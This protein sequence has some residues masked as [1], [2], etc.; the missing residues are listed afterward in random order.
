MSKKNSNDTIGNRT[1]ELPACSAVPQPTASPRVPWKQATSM[2]KSSC[3]MD[4]T[5][6]SEMP[7]CSAIDLAESRRSSKISSWIWSIISGVVG[8]R[9]Y[10]QPGTCKTT[11]RI[12]HKLQVHEVLLQCPLLTQHSFRLD[13]NF[14]WNGRS[15]GRWGKNYNFIFANVHL[16]FRFSL[17]NECRQQSNLWPLWTPKM[18]V[19]YI[20][21]S[22]LCA[23][24]PY[25]ASVENMVSPE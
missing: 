6:S 1:R 5:R 14:Q 3:M 21:I 20:S 24:N 18:F 11:P 12:K 8:L 7:S 9:T 23:L 25:P 2:S 13:H 10:Q 19:K 15:S 16:K 4:P 17:Y 22:L